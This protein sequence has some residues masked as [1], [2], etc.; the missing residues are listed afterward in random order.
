MMN[1]LRCGHTQVRTENEVFGSGSLLEANTKCESCG[2][3]RYWAH[4]YFQPATR[5]ETSEFINSGALEAL[6][7]RASKSGW[8]FGLVEVRLLMDFMYGGEPSDNEKIY[9]IEA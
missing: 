5:E 4:G 3:E 8:H 1:C 9:R 7:Y 2:H 6:T